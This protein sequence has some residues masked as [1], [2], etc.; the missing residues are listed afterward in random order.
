MEI[1]LCLVGGIV[2]VP[3][4]LVLVWQRHWGALLGLVALLPALG[5]LKT[6]WAHDDAA[7]LNP[8]L[9]RTA[10]SLLLFGAAFSVGVFL[11]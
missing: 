6:A 7:H 2:L 8:A 10:K 9:A 4:A 11:W 5:V 1:T 3:L